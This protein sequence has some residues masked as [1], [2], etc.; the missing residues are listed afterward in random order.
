MRWSRYYV[1]TT[2]EVPSDAEVVSHQLMIRAGMIRKVAAGIYTY[3]PLGWRSVQKM[4]AIVRRELAEGRL[5]GAVDARRAAG[6]AVAG[7]RPLAALR[8]G[9][10]AHPRPPRARVLL[11]PDPRGG[12]HRHGAPRRAQLPSAAGQPLPDPDQVPRRDPAALRPHAR[13]R[14][15]DEGRLLVPRRRRVARRDLRGDARRLLPHLRIGRPRLH[16]GRGGHRDDRRLLLARV[17]GGGGHRRER[18]R[19]LPVLRLRGQR[20]EGGDDAVGGAR[21]G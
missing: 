17:H 20:R 7:V 12:D 5:R 4:S 16:G 21:R 2:R 6:R 18:R 11:R 8:Q 3:L 9:A 14:V 1:F 15:P 19:A 10:A 13:P